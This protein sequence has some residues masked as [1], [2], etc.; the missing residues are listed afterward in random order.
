VQ[1]LRWRA[2]WALTMTATVADALMSG[3]DSQHTL[4]LVG[5]FGPNVDS[6][7]A[8]AAWISRC[9]LHRRLAAIER[10]VQVQHSVYSLWT[11]HQT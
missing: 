8:R 2:S 1:S 4:Q 3:V 11:R 7:A 5:G 10:P 9:R 6:D